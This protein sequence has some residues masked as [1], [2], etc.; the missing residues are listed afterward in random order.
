[1]RALQLVIPGPPRRGYEEQAL[2]GRFTR[3]A[4]LLG[5]GQAGLTGLLG[6]R[7]YELQVTFS[8]RYQL[9]ADANRLNVQS[10]PVVRGAIRDRFGVVLAESTENLQAVLIPDLVEDVPALVQQVDKIITL[11]DDD[12]QRLLGIDRKSNRLQPVLIKDNL[13]WAEFARLNVLT[14]QLTGVE[15]QYWSRG[16]V[17]L[18]RRTKRRVDSHGDSDRSSNPHFIF[19]HRIFI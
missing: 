7:L 15:A 14:P 10:V 3:R 18:V 2:R 8:P 6:L 1:M 16:A 5:S 4:L 19:G 12:R 9:L 13:S 17:I 11:G